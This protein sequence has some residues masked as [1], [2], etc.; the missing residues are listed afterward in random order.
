[1]KHSSSSASAAS[2]YVGRVRP[3]H[4]ELGGRRTSIRRN[5]PWRIETFAVP[6]L[7]AAGQVEARE[8][9]PSFHYQPASG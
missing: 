8:T 5:E 4:H 7:V 1:M 2:R 9:L 6:Q 3:G